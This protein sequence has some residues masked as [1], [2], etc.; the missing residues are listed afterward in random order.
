MEFEQSKDRYSHSYADA[1]TS[2]KAPG[3]KTTLDKTLY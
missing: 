2:S 3:Y 1:Y